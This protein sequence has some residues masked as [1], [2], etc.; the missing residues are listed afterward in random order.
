MNK[1]IFALILPAI[2]AFAA[3]A[4]T[5]EH[6]MTT[7]SLRWHKEGNVKMS[8]SPVANAIDADVESPIVTF[9]KWGRTGKRCACCRATSRMRSF[10]TRF[11]PTD[12]LS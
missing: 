11:L 8:A 1:Y 7:D 3:G 10:T 9:K 4:Q 2:T 6:I 5:F 12:S